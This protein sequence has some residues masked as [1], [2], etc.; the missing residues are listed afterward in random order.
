MIYGFNGV[1]SLGIIRDKAPHELPPAAWSDGQN[2]RFVDDQVIKAN[3]YQAVFGTPTI[4]PLWLFPVPGRGVY[5]WVYAGLDKVYVY[6][7]TSHEN[8][9]PQS[10]GVDVDFTGTFDTPWSG[11]VLGGV[12]ILNNTVQPPQQWLPASA[13][14]RLVDLAN[15]PAD[16]TCEI[17]RPYRQFLVA[18]NV[19]KSG[20]RYPLTLKWS[21]PADPG[22]V[23]V[24]WDETDPTRDAGEYTFADTGDWLV[25]CCPLRDMN[26][27]YK[28]NSVWAMQYIGG[29]EIFRFTKLFNSFGALGPNC[30]TEFL[31][32]RHL[33]LSQGDVIVHDGQQ[34]ESIVQGKW[35]R[36]MLR[37]MNSDVARRNFVVTNQARQEVWICV[38]TGDSEWPNKAIIWNFVTGA[39]G[40]RDLPTVPFIAGGIIN[41]SAAVDSWDSEAVLTWGADDAS[42]GQSLYSQNNFGLLMADYTATMLYKMEE[43]STANGVAETTRIERTGIGIPLKQNLPPDFTSMKFIR[44]VWPRITGLNG[45]VVNVTVGTQMEIDGDVTWGTPQAYTIGVTKKID[46]L[47]TGRLLAIR[48]ESDTALDWILHGYEIDVSFRGS[49]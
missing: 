35:R 42:W 38:A 12:G 31:S 1:G 29:V 46:V 26:I 6:D 49:H 43:T 44:N 25:D 40:E 14:T 39:I 23:P 13:G 30:I 47:M 4:A 36:W 9:T 11:G 41:S 27:V 33:V 17:I 19:I 45:G 16:T 15:W 20:V 34:A 37:N 48:I 10:A 32:G 7:G 21:H 18:L 3:G 24:S 8:I 5:S 28:E 2:I 22:T